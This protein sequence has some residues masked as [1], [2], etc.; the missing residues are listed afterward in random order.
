[1]LGISAYPSPLKERYVSP[2]LGAA[3]AAMDAASGAWEA[4]RATQKLSCRRLPSSPAQR[5]DPAPCRCEA[6]GRSNVVTGRGPD[7]RDERVRIAAVAGASQ[8][9]G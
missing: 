2:G 4:D 5:G 6:S 7:G 1:M 8:P 3:F 9:P